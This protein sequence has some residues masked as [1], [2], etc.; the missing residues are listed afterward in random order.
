MKTNRHQIREYAFQTLFAMHSNDEMDLDDFFKYLTDDESAVAPEYYK[1]LVN[2][3]KD[4]K[5][6]I[7]EII[8]S[9]L[10]SKWTISRLNKSDLII[11]E[12]GIYEMDFEEDVPDK[13][14]INEALE[15]A[16]KFSDEKS[17]NFINAI[18]DKNMKKNPE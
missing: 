7:D 8:K 15:L 10:D 16:K 4:N 11:L 1:E 3:V 14:A 12:L 9:F 6:K 2:G 5:E 17:S 18:L 13:V